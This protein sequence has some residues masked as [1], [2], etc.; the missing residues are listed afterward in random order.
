[1]VIPETQ[2]ASPERRMTSMP[3]L[4]LSDS[5]SIPSGLGRITKDLAVLA[6]RLPQYRIGTLGKGG[7]YSSQLPFA[8]YNFP[9]FAQWG[10]EYIEDVWNDFAG[11]QKGIVFTIWDLS[12]LGWLTRPRMGGRLQKFLESVKFRKIGYIPVDSYGV[13]GRLTALAADALSGF[14][15]VLAY[16]LFGKEILERTMGQPVDWMPHG[17][18]E[19]VFLPRDKAPGRMVLGVKET[20]IVIGMVA[21]N[22]SRKDWATAFGA[23]AALRNKIPNLIFWAHTDIAV[24]YWNMMALITDF[25]LRDSVVLTFTGDYSSEQLSYLYSACDLTILPSL[26]EGFGLPIVESMACGVPC[27]HGFYGGGVELI[28]DGRFLVKP[29]TERLDGLWNSVRPVYDPLDWTMAMENCLNIVADGSMKDV[30]TRAVEHLQW[31]N[32]WPGAWQKFFERTAIC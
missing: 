28:P 29:V 31:C 19:R 16:T 24:R 26:G 32:L 14:D 1:V 3:L 21:T 17:Y 25:G 8:Q 7:I 2:P 4:F 15:A 9:Q 23:I 27:I 12:R 6:S 20:D 5:P 18:N 10:E 22:Q 11:S 13:G 30:C